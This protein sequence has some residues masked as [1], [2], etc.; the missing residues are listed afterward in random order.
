[1]PVA[2][3]ATYINLAKILALIESPAMIA[4]NYCNR[5]IVSGKTEKLHFPKQK[6]DLVNTYSGPTGDCLPLGGSV[7]CPVLMIWIIPM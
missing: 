4:R 5:L 3:V 6:E 2:L 1:M 7:G